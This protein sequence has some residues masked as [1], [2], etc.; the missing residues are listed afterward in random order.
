MA[1]TG[2]VDTVA[3]RITVPQLLLYTFAIQSEIGKGTPK[4]QGLGI[5]MKNG[6]GMLQV[7]SY[8]DTL[9]PL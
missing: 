8:A 7:D 5:K 1:E 9:E 3:F 2:R 6:V 4:A